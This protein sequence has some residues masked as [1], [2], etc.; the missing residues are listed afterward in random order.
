[1]KNFILQIYDYLSAHKRVAAVILLI[2]LALSVVSVLRLGFQEDISAFLPGEQREQLQDVDGQQR[3]AILFRGG[4]IDEKLDAMYA[5]E[6]NWND[7]CPD[8][9]ISA[10]SESA[11]VMDVFGFVNANWPY[12][13][14]SQ[15]YARMDSLLAVPG[16]VEQA[17][18]EDKEALYGGSSIQERYMRADPLRLYT[19]VL[20]R[21]QGMNAGNR[22][23]DG[24]LF[25]EDGETGILFFD[26]PYGGSE[27]SQ[28]AQLM[29]LVDQV[30][31]QTAAEYP[32]VTV[33]SSGGPEVAVENAGRIKKDTFL[34][35]ALAALLICIVLW[36]SY[37]RFADVLWILISIGMGALFALGIIALFKSS[38]SIIVLGIGCTI[39]G[40]AVNY[41]LHYVDH[42][43]YQP[44][45]RKALAEQVNPLLVGNIT[46]VGAFLSLLLLKADAL[47]DFGFIGAMM[48]IGTILFVLVFLPVFVPAAKGPRN[49]ITLD[50]DRHIHAGAT[51][52]KVTFAVFL[53][54]T[55]L[56]WLMGS[57]V[58]FDADLHHINYM[59]R[60]Q[61]DGFAVLETLRPDASAFPVPDLEEQEERIGLWN[62]FWE[63]HA[64]LPDQL[65]EAGLSEGFTAHAFQPFFDALDKQWTPQ[66]RAYFQP[67]DV[68]PETSA[69][70]QL[71]A[72]LQEDFNTIGLLCSLIVFIFLWFS[73]GSL[74]L[75]IL[76][77]LPLAVSWIWIQGIMGLTGL[78]FNIVNIILATFI[79][80]QGDDYSIFITEGLMYERATGKRILHSY[81]NAV[82]L[83]AIIMFIGIGALVV[84]R[85]PAMRSLGLVT[86]IGMLT[87]VLMAYYLPP[88][89]FRWLTARKGEPRK[90]PIGL[91]RLLA[92]GFIIVTMAVSMTLLSAWAWV[93]FLFGKS[94][95]RRLGFHKLL[96]RLSGWAIRLIP[97]GH[98]K[99]YNPYG[100][101][102]SKPAIYICNH[103]SH[104]DV[105]PIL[106][107][108]PKLVFLT[109]EWAWNFPLYRQVL[110]NAEYYPTSWGLDKGSDH[111]RDLVER[112][113]SIVAFVEGTR[114]MD[115]LTVQRFHRG[116]FLAARNLG[117]DILPLCI[118]GFGFALPKHDFMLRRAG[119]SLEVGKRLPVPEEADIAVFT[120]EMRHFY[121]DWYARIRQE[122]ETAAYCA[123]W[124]K[125]QYLYKGHDARKECRQVLRKEVYA[126]IDALQGT[127]LVIKEAGC[128]VYA[129]LVAL[130][131]P[132]IRVT[133][134]EAD[135]EKYLTAVRCPGVPANLTYLNESAPQE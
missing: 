60:D 119:L 63:R 21:F 129:L 135:E 15:D 101:D 111:I 61:E 20:Q 29:Q 5:F 59:T 69:A 76:S 77:F 7:A 109:N 53:L 112:G 105:L 9:P 98:Y 70:S 78:Q 132:E 97:G 102:F 54:L 118:H 115:S 35:L 41:P 50:W 68:E 62:G 22:L 79:F 51:T 25:T 126:A 75:S 2:V 88:L 34:A 56:F 28:N 95:K 134:Y 121:N 3:M 85:H 110:R 23:E 33:T 24:C 47:H 57:R 114:S 48:L 44:D 30:K 38:V 86:V 72:A 8:L 106:A 104:L 1:M 40:I 18:R 125:Y 91:L 123:P 99:L 11:Q 42:L 107:L 13:L 39:I 108:N 87:V 12:F 17:L 84:A 83:S 16:Y 82:M 27:T 103:Q 124:V 31:A 52:R 96:S 58:G 6:Q 128:G 55:G 71:V 122:R 19:P 117:L 93:Y 10:Q 14:Q 49:A 81:K 74:E 45:K 32:D 46:T 4:G 73:F 127:E 90:V 80:G 66:E 131:H 26:S 120:R 89:V 65:V 37:K 130:A 94:E 43:K 100:E 92:T 67:I 133:A 116:P 36:F 64:A 113:Y